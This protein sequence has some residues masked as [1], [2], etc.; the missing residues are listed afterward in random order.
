MSI[1]RRVVLS[2]GWLLLPGSISVTKNSLAG[3]LTRR[4]TD[5]LGEMAAYPLSDGTRASIY[6][7]VH[8]SSGT[9]FIVVL[10]T[11]APSPTVEQAGRGSDGTGRPATWFGVGL[12]TSIDSYLQ[13]PSGLSP[14]TAYA[15]YA[16]HQD[17]MSTYSNMV[18]TRFTTPAAKQPA[19]AFESSD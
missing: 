17:E 14:E 3:S 10:P 9:L 5:V 2:G 6:L 4:D 15:V 16:V 11:T 12:I 8:V 13:G 19:S 18:S 1:S 7:D